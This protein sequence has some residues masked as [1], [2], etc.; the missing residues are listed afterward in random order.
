MIA[1]W[2]HFTIGQPTGEYLNSGLS[3]GGLKS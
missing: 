1:R 3:W 2:I